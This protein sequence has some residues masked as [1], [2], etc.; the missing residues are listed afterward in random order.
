MK[1]SRQP[2]P[3]KTRFWAT[4]TE[5]SRTSR[6]RGRLW[7]G[8][9]ASALGATATLIGCAQF[10][11]VTTTPVPTAATIVLPPLGFSHLYGNNALAAHDGFQMERQLFAQEIYWEVA[12]T[13]G[14]VSA[15]NVSLG[16]PAA[17]TA[18]RLAVTSVQLKVAAEDRGTITGVLAYNGH[19][20]QESYAEALLDHVRQIGYRN[21]TT[22]SVDV[23][24]TEA[25]HHATL[26]WTTQSGY[27]YAVFDGDLKGSSEVPDPG[28]T[29]LPDPLPVPAVH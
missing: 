16:D 9:V 2:C 24:F 29:P 13:V 27:S 3:Q 12:I 1:P 15:G 6:Q 25:D 23:Y 20:G 4:S 7:C 19:A 5:M 28:Q 17:M 14:P 22:A 10:T 8:M 26:T 11:V 18:A 21:V